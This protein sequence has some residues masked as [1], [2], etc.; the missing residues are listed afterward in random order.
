[1]TDEAGATSGAV[2]GRKRPGRRNSSELSSIEL[3]SRVK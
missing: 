3:H 1:M 2:P